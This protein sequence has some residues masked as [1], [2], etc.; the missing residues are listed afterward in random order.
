MIDS[1]KSSGAGA[2]EVYASPWKF[3]ESLEFLSDTFTPRKTKSNAN[4]ED[5]GSP[6][7]DAKPPFAKTSKKFTLAQNNEIHR[8]MSTATTVLKSVISS[9]KNQKPQGEDVDDTFGKLL[10]GQLKLIPECDLKDDLKIR[11]QQ[12]V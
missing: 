8:A 3:Y 1:S 6:Y 7:V 12:M 4:D 2:D 10:V 11:L 9:K 5:D